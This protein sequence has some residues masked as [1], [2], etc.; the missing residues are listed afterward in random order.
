MLEKVR[1]VINYQMTIAELLGLVV[2]LGMPYLAIGTI[3][4]FTHADHLAS[5]QGTDLVVS[6][7]G[8]IASWPLLVISNVLD[9]TDSKARPAGSVAERRRR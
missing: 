4:S 5:L 2:I 8:S 1:T 6:F 9:M 7:L 3:W